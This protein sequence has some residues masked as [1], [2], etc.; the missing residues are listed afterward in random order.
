MSCVVSVMSAPAVSQESG[1]LLD[2]CGSRAREPNGV[3]RGIA[4]RRGVS[5][6]GGETL[7]PGTVD[8]GRLVMD[9]E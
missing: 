4:P 8:G 3:L 7:C 1:L 6:G 9:E 5:I 2:S